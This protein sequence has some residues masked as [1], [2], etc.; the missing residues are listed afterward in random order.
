[1]NGAKARELRSLANHK[2]KAW[3]VATPNVKYR[4]EKHIKIIGNVKHISLQLFTRGSG[5]FYKS[6]KKLYKKGE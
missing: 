1:M 2:I 6:L 4:V 5:A 3:R